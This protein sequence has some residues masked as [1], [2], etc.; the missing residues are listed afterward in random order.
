M[1]I[2]TLALFESSAPP[3][4]CHGVILT[5]GGSGFERTKSI[6]P[7]Q[8]QALRRSGCW[9]IFRAIMSFNSLTSSSYASSLNPAGRHS[10]GLEIPCLSSYLSAASPA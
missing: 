7:Q 9:G 1:N 2:V 8:Y 5:G 3:A 4:G 6:M 10:G